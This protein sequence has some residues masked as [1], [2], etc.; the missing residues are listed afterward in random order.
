MST[1]SLWRVESR[2]TRLGP[3]ADDATWFGGTEHVLG[4][5]CLTGEHTCGMVPREG[6]LIRQGYRY[7]FRTLED[8]KQWFGRYAPKLADLGFV[9]SRYTAPEEEVVDG[10]GEVMF[11]PTAKR[12]F[13]TSLRPL[14]TTP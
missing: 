13:S 3:Y 8:A 4:G 14:F 9:L 10:A 2:E 11:P 7:G 12:V 6:S 5:S 1:A